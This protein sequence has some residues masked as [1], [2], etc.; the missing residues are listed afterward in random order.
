VSASVYRSEQVIHYRGTDAPENAGVYYGFYISW[1]GGEDD[2]SY[3]FNNAERRADWEKVIRE[4][5]LGN[6]EEYELL[7]AAAMS[8]C[9]EWGPES[10]REGIAWALLDHYGATQADGLMA[11]ASRF[12]PSEP[13]GTPLKPEE[14]QA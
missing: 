5:A 3:P 6:F 12:D 4:S 2:S 1:S 14:A 7:L 8:A 11:L 13:P 9:A 10:T